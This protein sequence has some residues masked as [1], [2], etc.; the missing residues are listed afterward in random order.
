MEWKSFFCLSESVGENRKG[1]KLYYPEFGENILIYADSKVIGDSKLGN[2]IIVSANTLIK[3][4][5]IPDNS[6]VFGQSPNL[7]IKTKCEKEIRDM[8]SHIW[9]FEE[10]K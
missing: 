10:D 2:N 6:I 4:A 7:L 8:M 5:E 9:I 3:D 1:D